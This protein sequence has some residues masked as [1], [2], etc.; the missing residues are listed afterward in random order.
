MDF[1]KTLQSGFWAKHLG[2]VFMTRFKM[3]LL[4]CLER[5]LVFE[6]QSYQVQ[7]GKELDNF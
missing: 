2:R 5:L 4:K 7:P 6:N 3:A 1:N